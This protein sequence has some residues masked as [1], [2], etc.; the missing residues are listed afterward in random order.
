MILKELGGII[1]QSIEPKKN[2]KL[3]ICEK[4]ENM[5]RSLFEVEQFLCNLKKVKK[6][7]LLSKL[8]KP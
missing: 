5:V 8:F 1:M 6:A 3:P 7:I 4:K 2:S